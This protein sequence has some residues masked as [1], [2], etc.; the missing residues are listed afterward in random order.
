ML[1]QLFRHQEAPRDLELLVLD[2][3]GQLD[4]FQPVTERRRHGI[5]DVG[6]RDE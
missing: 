3:A 5:E 1:L 6:R 4:H 2:V